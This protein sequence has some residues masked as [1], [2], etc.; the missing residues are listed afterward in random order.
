MAADALSLL[1]A[2]QVTK[3][4]G[5]T[6]ALDAV[7]FSVRAGEVSVLIG[8]NGA[9]KSTLMR[10]LAGVEQPSSG[11]LLLDG[12]EVSFA[13]VREASANGIGIVHQELSFCPN[14]SVAE[15][16]FLNP[17]T[18]PGD[19][20][21]QLLLTPTREIAAARALLARL[22]QP[23]DPTIRMGDLRIGQQQIVEIA[24]AV[25]EDCRVLIL[26]EPTSALSDPEVKVL[27]RLIDELKRA[28][29]AIVYI[30][31]RLEELLKIGDTI[32]VLRDGRLVDSSP[33]GET[34]L[35]WIVE[36]MLGSAGRPERKSERSTPGREVLS[37]HDLH[38]RSGNVSFA[39]LSASFRAGEITAIFG[40]LGAGRTELLEAISGLRPIGSGSIR[41]NGEP[42][43]DLG[44]AFRVRR[45]LLLVPEDRQRDGLFPNLS[46][47]R[48][49]G[50]SDLGQAMSRTGISQRRETSVIARMMQRLGVKAASGDADIASLS[51]GNQQK[52]VIGRTLLPGPSAILLD[53]PSR[54][55]DVGARS[56][57]FATMQQLAVEGLA[58]VFATSD[59]V[60][61]LAIAD[62]I[63]VIAGG[64]I[65]ADTPAHQT[66]EPALIR[67]ANTSPHTKEDVRT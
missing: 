11:H 50:I 5:A 31:H 58:V 61:A 34:S 2:R 52:V 45:G 40:L 20:G 43:E 23:I 36:R 22:E 60:E 33:V 38:L 17:R 6:L 67:A 7:D 46:V 18:L 4:Y 10:I 54:G 3:R 51:G 39:G 28:G 42:I 56:E 1:E 15:N 16:I 29:V 62:R 48:N 63:I 12:K 25:A 19:H 55:V 41:L 30:S 27:F 66:D 53:E 14:L 59:V 35:D 65:S 26:D 57:I 32:T 49:I 13:N 24:K 47:G 44:I 8:E 37:L 21:N 9:G 64:A